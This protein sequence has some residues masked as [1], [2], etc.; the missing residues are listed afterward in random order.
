MVE[1]SYKISLHL[2]FIILINLIW[3]RRL[4][5]FYFFYEILF[6]LIMF[7]IILLGYSYER[8]IACYLMIFYSFVFSRPVLIIL[9][10]FDYTFLIKNWLN[11]S[12]IIN[13]FL[14]GSFIVKFPIFGFHYWLPVAHVEASTIGSILL[15]GILLKIGCIGIFY[16]VSYL[17]FMIKFHW[18]S[19][20]TLVVILIILMLRDLKI[21]IAYSSVA[22]IRIIF[23]VIIIG[24]VVGKNGALL[25]IFYHG[26]ISPLIFWVVGL[27]SWWKTRSL[28]VV[29]FIS[30]SYL[31]ILFVFAV[32][33]LNIG[34]PPFIGFLS[35]VLIL[36][37]LVQ[38]QLILYIFVIRILLRAYY[39][40]YFFWSF[41]SF[42]GFVFKLNLFSLDV[43]VFLLLRI[44]LNF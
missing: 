35:E 41:N 14:A 17:S 40:I 22:H 10:V 16:I 13:F 34:F 5:T 9:L 25:I 26:F 21:M 33:I 18:L 8:L 39:N 6:V 11:Y 12:L 4:L 32:S 30:F 23:Y 3:S 20:R 27:L 2:L 19:M 1:F 31:F 29:K 44:F 43:F 24:R 38:Y 28:I 37:S 36:K 15:A 42:I 7:V